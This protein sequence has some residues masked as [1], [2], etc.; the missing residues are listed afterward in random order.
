MFY[1]FFFLG[2]LGAEVSI[3]LLGL[4]FK[5]LAVEVS[6]YFLTGM[7]AVAMVMFLFEGLALYHKIQPGARREQSQ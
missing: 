7:T 1:S 6:F 3:I 4:V 5:S 2:A